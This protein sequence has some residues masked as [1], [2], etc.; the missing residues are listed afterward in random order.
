MLSIG[1]SV[2][3]AAA[4]TVGITYPGPDGNNP[5]FIQLPH[6]CPLQER[7]KHLYMLLLKRPGC[8]RFAYILIKNSYICMAC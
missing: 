8:Q 7:W 4:F 6:K 3:L 1:T 2:L 5:V